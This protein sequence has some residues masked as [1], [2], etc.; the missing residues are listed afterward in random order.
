M[1]CHFMERSHA[2]LTKVTRMAMR[3]Q[4]ECEKTFKNKMLAS[5]SSKRTVELMQRRRQTQ[6]RNPTTDRSSARAAQSNV[7]F[8]KQN[9]MMMLATGVTAAGWML[10]VLAC[11]RTSVRCQ[12]FCMPM[13][14][15][16]RRSVRTYR[17]DRDRAIHVRAICGTSSGEWAANDAMSIDEQR[18]AV[19]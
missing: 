10:T 2:D 17:C 9:A 19:R 4:C 12:Q 14:A 11:E 8:I 13:L 15:S 18:T 16:W 7:Q 3:K 1:L 6:T 5:E